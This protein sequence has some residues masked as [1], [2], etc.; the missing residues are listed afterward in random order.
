M[1]YENDKNNLLDK[2]KLTTSL[3]NAENVVK[4]PKKPMIKK[5][6]IKF[7]DKLFEYPYDIKY[8]IKNDPITLTH[9]VANKLLLKYNLNK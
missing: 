6:L 9:N 2:Y 7:S 8:P 3:E 1:T 5:Y 4:E